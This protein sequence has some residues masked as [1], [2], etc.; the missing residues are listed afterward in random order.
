V[1]YRCDVIFSPRKISIW[2][3]WLCFVATVCSAQTVSP[4]IDE[5]VVKGTGRAAKGKIEYFNN[6]LQ[7]LNVVL[8]AKSFSVSVAGE[9]SYR[10]LDNGIQLKLSTMS[11]R[12]PPQQSY[13]VYYQASSDKIPAWF[14]VYASFSG[15]RERTPQGLRIQV[16]LPHTIYL[17]PKQSIHKDELTVVTS[18]Y[19]AKDKK[20]LV[21][22]RNAGSAFGRVLESDISNGRARDTQGGFPLFPQSERQIE[23]P[24][25]ADVIPTKLVLHLEHFALE[26]AVS[27][28]ED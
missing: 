19:L 8:E 22:V 5:N 16:Q 27:Q 26:H 11:F 12:L 25:T 13:T 10:P 28:V 21:R 2:A 14:V 17:L 6:S 4:L 7:P 24:W 23:I 9:V 20:V 3:L 18:D 1:P 15:F